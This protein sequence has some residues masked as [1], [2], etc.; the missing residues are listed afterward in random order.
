MDSSTVVPDEAIIPGYR[1]PK[2]FRALNPFRYVVS[3][4]VNMFHSKPSENINIS[5]E[6]R[7]RD[8]VAVCSSSSI[9]R[10]DN[11]SESNTKALTTETGSSNVQNTNAMCHVQN[12][13]TRVF[14]INLDQKLKHDND[15][16]GFDLEHAAELDLMVQKIDS[17]RSSLNYSSHAQFQGSPENDTANTPQGLINNMKKEVYELDGNFKR[18]RLTDDKPEKETNEEEVCVRSLKSDN[19]VLSCISDSSIYG[20]FRTGINLCCILQNGQ[21]KDVVVRVVDENLV[22]GVS[23]SNL[24][25]STSFSNVNM[26]SRGLPA[27]M[28]SAFGYDINH[29]FHVSINN[30]SCTFIANSEAERNFLCDELNVEWLAVRESKTKL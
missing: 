21:T 25:L 13:N 26:I 30:K 9:F 1:K 18:I 24:F 6:K 3:S 27:K 2:I 22:W 7:D 15:T 23:T 29:I 11:F 4:F 14:R 5:A 10:S 28:A 8:E 17:K 20:N 12:T 16:S 19:S